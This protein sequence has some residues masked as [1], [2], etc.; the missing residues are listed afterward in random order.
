MTG[1]NESDNY[2]SQLKHK[3]NVM[4]KSKRC[5]LGFGFGSTENKTLR[6]ELN[7]TRWQYCEPFFASSAKVRSDYKNSHACGAKNKRKANGEG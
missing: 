5:C 1:G 4:N 7:L 3:K 2:Q 6:R